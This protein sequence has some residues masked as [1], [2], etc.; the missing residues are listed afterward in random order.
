M[1]AELATETNGEKRIKLEA[2]IQDAKTSAEFGVRKVQFN[3]Y[4]AFT[5][6]DLKAMKEVWS[7]AADV[8]CVHP[9][10]PSIDGIDLVMAS[11]ASI[12]GSGA[13]FK[14]QPSKTRISICGQTA[15]CSCVE[16]TPNGGML[17]C[18]NVYRRE[19]GKWRMVL[20][21]ASPV[22]TVSRPPTS[23]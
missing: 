3:F 2:S 10:M 18:L 19:A 6:Q 21:M 7:T 20:H 8:R 23:L 5:N 9:G 12:F 17:E 1:E 22:V 11:W 4:E 14:I 16:E 15:L 13:A